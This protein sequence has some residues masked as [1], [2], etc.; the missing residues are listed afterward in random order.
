MARPKK[1]AE[2]RLRRARG[3][4]CFEMRSSAKRAQG[5]EKLP[6]GSIILV[7]TILAA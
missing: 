4:F 6:V 3:L 2:K 7:K 5:V 1:D